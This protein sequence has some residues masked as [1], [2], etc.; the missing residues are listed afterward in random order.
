MDESGVSVVREQGVT[1]V[2]IRGAMTVERVGELRRAL[3]EAFALGAAVRLSLSE[4]TRVDVSGLQLICSAHRSSLANGQEFVVTGCDP[5]EVGRVAKL[6][7]M[8][9]HL[10]CAQDRAGSCIW[11]KEIPA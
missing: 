4:V 1:V 7:G 6:C 2:G 10:G 3:L 9:R 11:K 5:G 8:P